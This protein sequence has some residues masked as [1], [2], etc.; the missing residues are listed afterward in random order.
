MSRGADRSA[1]VAGYLR[2]RWSG[3]LQRLLLA[4][5]PARVSRSAVAVAQRQ[6]RP[7]STIF[8]MLGLPST[9][10]ES[11][12]SRRAA[13]PGLLTRPD[14]TT[15]EKTGPPEDKFPGFRC[16]AAAAK[17]AMSLHSQGAAMKTRVIQD[18]PDEPASQ[19]PAAPP[20]G[21]RQPANPAGRMGRWIVRR[22][23]I[24]LW[25]AKLRLS[26]RRRLILFAPG[27]SATTRPGRRILSASIV[28]AV[29]AG[30]LLAPAGAGAAAGPG[31][32]GSMAGLVPHRIDPG[33]LQRLLD[34]IVAAGAPGAAAWVRDERGIQ[35]A[36][37]G[38]A[39]LRTGRPMRPGLHF[40]A[41][42]L[43][44]VAGRHRRAAAGRRGPVVAPRHRGTLAA[45]DL[46]LRRPGHHP[47]A[48]QPH[49]RPPTSRGSGSASPGCCSAASGPTACSS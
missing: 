3:C 19:P 15:R 18:E 38:V 41:A 26:N 21:K 20:A 17:V 47:P 13:L 11:P 32:R 45:G 36:A 46:A 27:R 22:R 48:A 43:T 35:R 7:V 37:S 1:R 25:V 42:S 2:A 23:R 29:T 40:R 49:Q 12:G 5:V 16:A 39:D 34:Q 9:G 14:S 10:T 44:Q 28:L 8:G 30:V 4:V 33:E 6:A 31:S 24:A